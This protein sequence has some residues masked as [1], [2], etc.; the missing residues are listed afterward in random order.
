MRK[1]GLIIVFFITAMLT[2]QCTEDDTIE[3]AE[4]EAVNLVDGGEEGDQEIDTERDW[5]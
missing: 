3:K 4:Y 2:A 1:L 5:S